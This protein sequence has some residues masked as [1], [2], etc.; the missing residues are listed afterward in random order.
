MT[1]RTLVA[2]GLVLAAVLALLPVDQ[3]LSDA[4]SG[5][6]T[7]WLSAAMEAVSELRGVVFFAIASAATLAAG[8]A[9]RR[10]RMRR[11][12]AAMLLA[13][14]ASAA[15]VAVV[16]PIVARD[17]PLGPAPPEAGETWL[18]RRWGRF[19]SGH[20]AAAFSAASALAAV[21][22][23]AAP[24]GYGLGA[25]VGYERMYRRVHFA[26]DCLAGAW[27][28]IAAGR[29]FGRRLRVSVV[30]SPADAVLDSRK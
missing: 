13:V 2:N 8:R 15:V 30:D 22:P 24:F 17:G 20:T 4:V 11:A 23:A 6:R 16:K 18:S 19:P 28:G 7:P 26:S 10:V 12:G 21:Y 29:F 9:A 3:R 25:V 5:A 27:I 14:L 1:A